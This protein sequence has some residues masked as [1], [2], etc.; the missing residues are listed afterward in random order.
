MSEVLNYLLKNKTISKEEVES[1]ISESERTGNDVED[2]ILNRRLIQDSELLEI[3]SKIFNFPGIN[4]LNKEIQKEFLNIISEDIAENYK[5]VIFNKDGNVVSVAML[6]PFNYNAKEALEFITRKKQYEIKYFVATSQS[7]KYAIKQY[8]TID[9]ELK[10]FVDN[11]KNKEQLSQIDIKNPGDLNSPVVKI[12]S[13][14]LQHAIE[15]GSSDIHIEPTRE[16]VRVRYRVD[17]ELYTSTRLPRYMHSSIVARIKV[18]A[19]LKIDETRIPQDGRTNITIGDKIYDFRI[20]IIPISDGEK[21]VMRI[22]DTS[23]K[24]PT[25]EELGVEAHNFELIAD[26]L[27]LKT[28][29]ILICGPTGSGKSTTLFSMLS[30]LN[31]ENI[32]IVTLEDPVEYMIQ[33]VNHSQVRPEIGYTFASGIRSFLRQDPDI[34]MVGEIRDNETAELCVH[35]GLTGHLVLS[36]L[37]TNDAL[38]AIPRL[39][40]MKIES[41]L[42]SSS[43][44]LIISQRLVRKICKYCKTEMIIDNKIK[45]DAINKIKKNR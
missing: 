43:L 23:T 30:I 22:L 36:T 20:S 34:I 8:K 24:A 26:A 37:H 42:L 38:G 14:I 25:L 2:V 31:K 3:K 1:I 29:M 17:G 40:D 44:S 7:L 15:E 9:K 12:V 28:G 32:N 19:N 6:N 10:T 39:L 13:T 11:V 45:E 4:L 21:I 5:C 18:M 16:D 33:G 27:K 35:A 41:F